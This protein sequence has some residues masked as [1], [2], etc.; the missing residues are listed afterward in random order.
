MGAKGG[1]MTWKSACHHGQCEIFY[2]KR[3]PKGW[4]DVTCHYGKGLNLHG[5]KLI[6]KGEHIT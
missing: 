3:I 4:K 2:G 6:M 5:A 1:G